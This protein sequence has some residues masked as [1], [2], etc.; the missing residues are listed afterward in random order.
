MAT[1]EHPDLEQILDALCSFDAAAPSSAEARD[2]LAKL[3]RVRSSAEAAQAA[4]MMRMVDEAQQQDAAD[5]ALLVESERPLAIPPGARE[6]FVIDEIAL[7]LR[8]TRVAAS[9]RFTTALASHEHP[10]LAAAWRAGRIDARKVQI[11]GDALIEADPVFAATITDA[12]LDYA[13][14]HTAP[15]VRAWLLRRVIAANPEAA[16]QRRERAIAGRRVTFTPLPDGVAELSALMPAVQARRIFDT[17]TV[18]AHATD[19]VDARDLDQRRS[20]V[21]YDL[22]CGDATP[23]QVHLAVTVPATVLAGCSDQPGELAG[24]GPITAGTVRDLLAPEHCSV[25]TW[26]RLLTDPVTGVLADISEAR[27]RP[28]A[29]LERAVRARDVTC[30]FPGCRRPATSARNGV[31]VDHTVPWPTGG[32]SAANLAC[33]CRHHHRLKHSPGWRLS[34]ASDGVLTWTTPTGHTFTSR[35]WQYHDPPG[36]LDPPTDQDEAA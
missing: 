13:T 18:L 28:S 34:S 4:L 15:Q 6:E 21:L 2:N 5:D 35:P 25:Q 19:G 27:Y 30:R 8:C 20:D 11:I 33:L 32:T 22:T 12:A 24:Y 7:H 36:E 26:R 14:S 23:P 31:D 29:R 9:H 10:V 1:D 17:L 3:E 16:E